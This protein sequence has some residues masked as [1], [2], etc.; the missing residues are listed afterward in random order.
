MYTSFMYTTSWYA[1]DQNI[2]EKYLMWCLK[3]SQVWL[4]PMALRFLSPKFSI[5]ICRLWRPHLDP[6]LYLNGIPIPVVDEVKFLGL[7]YDNKLTF[8]PHLRYLKNKCMKGLNL[9]RVV[10]HTSQG[11]DQQN[12]HCCTYI[13]HLSDKNW[14]VVYG[15][16]RKSYTW[17]CWILFKSVLYDYRLLYA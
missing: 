12:K 13:D 4:T 10:A 17:E 15:S 16:A 14:C 6:E 2:T 7:I 8:L 5:C 3:K 9:I 1:T 11:A